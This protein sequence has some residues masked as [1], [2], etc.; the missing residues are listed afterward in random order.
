MLKAQPQTFRSLLQETLVSRCKANPAYSLRAFAK[1]L[2]IE[3]SF[4]S[5]ILS[6]KRPTTTATIRKLAERLNL[7]PEEA[8]PFI[9]KT[10]QQAKAADAD[11][12]NLALDQ[13]RM[14]SDWYH[15]AILELIDVK[16]FESDAAWI[17]KKLG[18]KK[19][20]AQTALERLERLEMIQKNKRGQYENTSGQNTTVGNEFTAVAF[21]KLQKQILL[22][23][24]E[25]LENLDIAERDHSSMTMAI[26]PLLLPEAKK[27]IR[28]FRR[29]LCAFL[30][31]NNRPKK[32]VFQ[33]SLSL[34]PVTI[35][36]GTL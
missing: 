12:Q 14:I 2:Q 16:G 17:A 31:E 29:E 33:L 20:E 7:S 35:S 9:S 36:K 34:F 23:S 4:L 8:A 25:A 11:F 15:Y 13:F 1:H 19:I 3:P 27:K 21:R 26:D 32:E 5:K 28:D 22:Q 10:T 30:Q 6:G 18:I 24:I